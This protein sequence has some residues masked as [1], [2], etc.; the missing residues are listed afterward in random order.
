M[1]ALSMNE[2]KTHD[3]SIPHTKSIAT[4]IRQ[5]TA[6]SDTQYCYYDIILIQSTLTQ[7]ALGIVNLKLLFNNIFGSFYCTHLEIWLCFSVKE[8]FDKPHS[9]IEEP[10]SVTCILTS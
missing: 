2:T 10:K 6:E 1:T 9:W 4:I 3:N 7:Y 5:S 8:L